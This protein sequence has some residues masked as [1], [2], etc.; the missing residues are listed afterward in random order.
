[1]F[2]IDL[3]TN[4]QPRKLSILALYLGLTM[5]QSLL[6]V[7]ANPAKSIVHRH[8]SSKLPPRDNCEN[9]EI[10]ISISCNITSCQIQASLLCNVP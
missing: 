4:S 5:M 9:T 2:Q 1:M 6:L 8:Y 7:I 3:Q 10:S